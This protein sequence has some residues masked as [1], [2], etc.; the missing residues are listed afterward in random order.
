MK[1]GYRDFLIDWHERDRASA[2][3]VIVCPNEYSLPWEP[4]AADRD[5][6]RWKTLPSNWGEFWVIEYQPVG[7]YWGISRLSVGKMQKP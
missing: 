4:A 7:G 2:A 5:V 3:E 6:L 1:T